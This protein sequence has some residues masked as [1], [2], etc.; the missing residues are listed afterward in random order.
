M[1]FEVLS[2]LFPVHQCDA[3]RALL[4]SNCSGQKYGYKSGTS[5]DAEDRSPSVC[6]SVIAMTQMDNATA[7]V[8]LMLGNTDELLDW[9]VFFWTIMLQYV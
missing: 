5:K 4:N 1:E 2:N 6:T 9:L 7:A 8:H 3:M